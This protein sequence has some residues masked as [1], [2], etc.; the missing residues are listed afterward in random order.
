MDSGVW[1]IR[2]FD[3]DKLLYERDVPA[4]TITRVALESLLR[5]LAA[6]YGLCD[7]EIVDSYLRAN[8]NAY[9]SLLEVRTDMRPLGANMSTP[10]MMLSCG[11]GTNFVA[12]LR[13]AKHKATDSAI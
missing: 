12:A 7:D 11:E 13:S 9:R 2:G 1:Q 4:G 8:C 3:G 10:A 5:T 6:K